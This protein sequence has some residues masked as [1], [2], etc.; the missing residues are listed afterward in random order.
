MISAGYRYSH[1]KEINKTIKA[2]VVLLILLVL[3][4]WSPKNRSSFY[5]KKKP[6]QNK[7]HTHTHLGV[8]LHKKL[9]A[10]YRW[11]NDTLRLEMMGSYFCTLISAKKTSDK[12]THNWNTHAD[13]IFISW[14]ILVHL[15]SGPLISWLNILQ[16]I[17]LKS[18][19]LRKKHV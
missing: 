17:Y 3:K 16:D 9:K 12:K 10:K 4:C 15:C 7:T 5:K 6:K 19:S 18:S 1:M 11:S 14:R 2:I 8:K 13:D